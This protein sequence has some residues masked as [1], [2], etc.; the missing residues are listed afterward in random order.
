MKNSVNLTFIFKF[1]PKLMLSLKSWQRL[2]PYPM[3]YLWPENEE[4]RSKFIFVRI[5]SDFIE[6]NTLRIIRKC[7]KKWK[8][9]TLYRLLMLQYS[10]YV[11]DLFDFSLQVSFISC[12]PII[13]KL[14]VI[15]FYY[16]VIA[17]DSKIRAKI[18]SELIIFLTTGALQ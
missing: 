9:K 2:H 6:L 1:E 3:F 8:S 17:L 5:I 11:E 16:I 7:F 13:L 14:N 4:S 10:K 15:I 12:L 18:T